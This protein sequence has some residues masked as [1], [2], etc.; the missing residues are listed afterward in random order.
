MFEKLWESLAAKDIRL[1]NDDTKIEIS[2][3]NLRRLLRQ[4]YEKGEANAP[5]PSES[6]SNPFAD[7]FKEGKP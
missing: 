5:R 1:H 4:F 6:A 2:S 7:L 3:V